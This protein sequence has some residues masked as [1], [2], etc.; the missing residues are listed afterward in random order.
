MKHRHLLHL[1]GSTCLPTPKYW[2]QIFVNSVI[3]VDIWVNMFRHKWL[4]YQKQTTLSLIFIYYLYLY[5]FFPIFL[6]TLTLSFRASNI[7]EKVQIRHRCLTGFVD[8]LTGRMK[9]CRPPE[10]ILLYR[11][12]CT[13]VKYVAFSV[14]MSSPFIHCLPEG[15]TYILRGHCHSLQRK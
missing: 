8:A 7:W 12:A 4:Q 3:L 14:I 6:N 13:R 11:F 15:H 10:I 1:W 2:G 5:S 9:T